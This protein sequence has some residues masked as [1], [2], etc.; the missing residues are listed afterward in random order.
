MAVPNRTG[1]KG[2][3]WRPGRPGSRKLSRQ[4]Q[5][6]KESR[7][8]PPRI[9]AAV[10]TDFRNFGSADAPKVP[11]LPHVRNLERQELRNRR[12][13]RKPT[14]VVGE[15][16]PFRP[17]KARLLAEPPGSPEHPP[18]DSGGFA[19]SERSPP[20]S[21]QKSL[22]TFNLRKPRNFRNFESRNFAIT[23]P[24][25]LANTDAWG[26]EKSKHFGPGRRL[27]AAACQNPSNSAAGLRGFAHPNRAKSRRKSR[28]ICEA[29]EIAKLPKL[30][31]IP[32]LPKLAS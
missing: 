9:A 13:S 4:P 16:Q 31:E 28:P 27:G 6:V 5:G 8:Q 23:E 19:N 7:A 26:L 18:S 15:P 17:E 14:Q 2:R 24:R 12:N 20:K 3:S 1:A 22:P 32:K 21:R 25:K 11:K 10:A 29:A 30:R